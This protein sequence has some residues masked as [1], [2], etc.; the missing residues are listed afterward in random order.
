MSQ[1]D[2]AERDFKSF[3]VDT[4]MMVVSP[5]STL[6]MSPSFD[7]AEVSTSYAHIE[8]RHHYL[9]HNHHHHHHY[10]S[11]D[12][13][14][15]VFEVISFPYNSLP[16]YTKHK[17]MFEINAVRRRL[18]FVVGDRWIK[19]SVL[20][21]SLIPDDHRGS[22]GLLSSSGRIMAGNLPKKDRRF[23]TYGL[24]NRKSSHDVSVKDRFQKPLSVLSSRILP[25]L[26]ISPIRRYVENY[27]GKSVGGKQNEVVGVTL[28]AASSR[29][30]SSS[31]R[32]SVDK[33]QTSSAPDLGMDSSRASTKSTQQ[34]KRS[35]TTSP[36]FLNR[37]RIM[38]SLKHI[39]FGDHHLKDNEKYQSNT[40]ERMKSRVTPNTEWYVRSSPGLRSRPVYCSMEIIQFDPE[41]GTFCREEIAYPYQP[42]A[43]VVDPSHSRYI[44]FVSIV[45]FLPKKS[46]VDASS[47]IQKRMAKTLQVR[48]TSINNITKRSMVYQ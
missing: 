27:N 32:L 19:Y 38:N 30:Q 35:T 17:I 41:T 9:S 2:R 28:A 37:N 24:F 1:S 31:Y 8:G 15:S 42:S 45:P 22:F 43:Y 11:Q 13:Y 26:S 48:T 20:R 16:W 21:P 10:A 5:V 12:D 39:L 46:Q 47:M 40:K 3:N 44:I 23:T 33:N 7:T 18:Q 4:R 36:E 25:F 34:R 14:K 6:T 29:T